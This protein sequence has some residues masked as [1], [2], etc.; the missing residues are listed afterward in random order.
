MLPLRPILLF[1]F[2]TILIIPL[3]PSGLYFAEG[4]VINSICLIDD[5]GI[6]VITGKRQY[7]MAFRQ[8]EH[9]R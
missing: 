7:L 9:V 4:F 3:I 2:N 1:L 5:E 6:V 8:L